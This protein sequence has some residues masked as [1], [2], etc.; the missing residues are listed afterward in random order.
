MIFLAH[1]LIPAGFAEDVQDWLLRGPCEASGTPPGGA[2]GGGRGPA[3][4]SVGSQR[5]TIALADCMADSG[6]C[7]WVTMVFQHTGRQCEEAANTA[8][9]EGYCHKMR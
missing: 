4:R 9:T 6:N 1:D 5:L 3:Q 8:D 7:A 2:P